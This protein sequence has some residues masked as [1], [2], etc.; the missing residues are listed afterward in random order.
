MAGKSPQD[1]EKRFFIMEITWKHQ[2]P[3]RKLV[4]P[5]WLHPITLT[6]TWNWLVSGTFPR[7]YARIPRI[8]AWWKHLFPRTEIRRK[9]TKKWYDSAENAAAE[10]RVNIMYPLKETCDCRHVSAKF[11]FTESWNFVLS[12]T[13]RD[14][15]WW[16]IRL[17]FACSDWSKL[18]RF[19]HAENLGSTWKLVYR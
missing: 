16:V 13:H 2:F 4:F 8:Y 1:N 5:Q 11:P 7:V 3:T 17:Y 19:V 18:D 9:R 14:R 10:T 12:S 15:G 6:E